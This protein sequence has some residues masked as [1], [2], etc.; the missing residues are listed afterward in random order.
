MDGSPFWLLIF[1]LSG[2]GLIAGSFLGLVSVRLPAGQDFVAGR[3]RCGSCS[4][5][6]AP[7]DLVPLLSYALAKG[8][9]RLCGARISLRYPAMELGCAALAAW[10]AILQPTPLA[11]I[12]TAL[13]GWQLLLIAV[14]DAEHFWLP[15]A[16][17]LPLLASGLAASALLDA[18]G[19]ADSLIG[20]IIG[21]AS[22]WSLAW[23]YRRLRGRDGLGGGD[24]WLF[25]AIGAWTGWIGLPSVL[26]WAAAAGLSVV[27]ATQLGR[28]KL[29]ASSRL[30]FGVFLAIGG[31]FTWNYGPLGF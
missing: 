27:L 7:R 15:D 16:L 22:L 20:A 12:L 14:V 4:R 3:S 23:A 11:A 17:T 1:S 25:A 10:A 8:R 21:F 13:L 30:P 5:T 2:L 6:L 28:R 9:C 29:T 31:W 26:L 24:P 18:P 19:L